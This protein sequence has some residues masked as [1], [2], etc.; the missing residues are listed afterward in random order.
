MLLSVGYA[1]VTP[2]FEAPDEASHFLYAHNILQTHT[3]PVLEDR[4]TVFASQST[5][6]HHPPLYYLIGAMLMSWTNRADLDSYL[7][8]NP[9]A[10][11]GTVT[12][13]NQNAY[14]HPLASTGDT[15]TAVW[16]MRLFSISLSTV[17]LWF[18]YRIGC[19]AFHS[20]SIGLTAML[21]TACIPQFIFI[22]A[23][24][25]NDNLVTLLYT[26]GLYYAV[27]LWRQREITW[28]DTFF[29]SAVLAAIAL[30]KLTGLSLFAVIYGVSVIGWITK[31]FSA[32]AVLRLIAVSLVMACVFSG[33]WY[34]RNWQ[35]YGDP[36]A[37]Q[38]TLAIWG[39]GYSTIS[40]SEVYAIWESFWLILGNFNIRGPEWMYVYA[41][42]VTL[43]G[44]IGAVLLFVRARASRPVIAFLALIWLGI[45]AS[46][47][48]AT[49][50]INISQG[51][52]LF[53]AIAAFTCLLSV[54]WH[55]LLGRVGKLMLLSP[56]VGLALF[57]PTQILRPAYMPLIAVDSLPSSAHPLD[58]VADALQI[59]GYELVSKSIAADGVIGLRLYLSGEHRDNPRLYVKA[60]DS[61]T[62]T[63]VG[64][65]D[66]Y[67]GMTPTNVT[68]DVNGL[69]RADIRVRIDASSLRTPTQINLVLGW[70][71][72]EHY[73]PLMDGTKPLETLMIDGPAW[74]NVSPPAPPDARVNVTFSDSIRLVGYTLSPKTPA[75]GDT[76]TLVLHW[77][78]DQSITEPLSAAVGLLDTNKQIVVQAD[79]I[80]AGYPTT[81]WQCGRAFTDTRTM[82]LPSS[83]QAGDYTLYVGWYH[84]SDGSRLAARGDHIVQSDN[85]FEIGVTVAQP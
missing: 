62:S 42:G 31:R 81:A 46:V 43:V 63:I 36:L 80:P 1:S 77:Q 14:L 37:L 44:M 35:L 33:W 61:A 75:A 67:P 21:F 5:Q 16:I 51:R 11:I 13:N 65:L 8:P 68:S 55:T 2:A 27:K 58:V 45:V 70:N 56:I 79:G 39:R 74:A 32:R 24:V 12:V 53:P 9:Y 18:V 20:A 54:G 10:S 59:R 47:L 50:Q 7:Q 3:L 71:A 52:L 78:C 76:L 38:A 60:L 48:I 22:S 15:D 23:S 29:I 30:S 41:N 34:L 64:T 6:R 4:A 49:R 40:Q 73:L 25:N 19:L 66:V 69:F 72:G 85:L 83:A 84:L 17:T 82:Q 28:R 26:I 57:V